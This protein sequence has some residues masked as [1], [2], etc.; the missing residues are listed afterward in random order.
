MG[1]PKF[2]GRPKFKLSK[3]W[4]FSLLILSLFALSIL[5][6]TSPVSEGMGQAESTATTVPTGQTSDS[7]ETIVTPTQDP[8]EMPPT[9]EEIGYTDGIII[10]S[11]ILIVI[12]LIGTLRETIRREGR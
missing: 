8:E 6:F 2:K 11:T 5:A 3:Q 9:P 7:T 10:W 1:N 12:L 4:I